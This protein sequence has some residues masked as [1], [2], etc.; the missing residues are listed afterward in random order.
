MLHTGILPHHTNWADFFRGLRVVVIDELHTYRGVFGSHV[1]NVLRRLRR[2]CRFYG[3]DPTFILTSATIAN[4]QEHAQRLVEAPVTLVDDNGAPSGMKHV[5]FYNPPLLDPALGLRRSSLLEAQKLGERFLEAGAQTIL[6]ARSRLRTE[7][8]LTYLREGYARTGGDPEALRGYR[9]GYLPAER[10]EIEAGLR[11]GQV[12]AVVATNALEL[13]IDIGSLQAAILTGFPGA[14]ASAWQQAGRAG[15]RQE[16]SVAILVASAGAL[17][18]YIIQHPEYFFE[19]TPEHALINPDNL[20]ILTDHVRCAAFELPF[21][22]GET[23]GTVAFTA[24]LLQLLA[25]EGD[26]QQSGDR[27]YWMASAYPGEGVS[28]RTAA[29]SPIVIMTSPSDAPTI[30]IGAL[31]R[32]AAPAL[33]HTGAIYLH[34]GQTYLVEN[35]DWEAG[36]A[37]VRAVEV[38][39]YTQASG[40][41]QVEVLSAHRQEQVGDLIQGH[42]D[43][44]VRSRVTS[45]RRVK[46]WSHETLGYGEV[47]LPETVLQT[48]GYWL[49]FSEELVERLR[50]EGLVAERS[51]RLRPELARPARP[52]PRS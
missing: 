4:P 13:G 9:G 38:D 25:A 30:S 44:E 18:Q 6:F 31:E 41:T 22:A 2:I 46:R 47:D 39:Y 1:A 52:G 24:E 32:E 23:F 51:Q 19:R 5:I 8:L 40:S 15:R 35:L 12:R 14:I 16:T 17:D 28:L 29:P 10:R 27:W 50:A 21:R 43:L 42:G 11:S 37:H 36:H 49:S 7:L 34:E 48:S 33:L 3:S 20:V 45:Y 26:V